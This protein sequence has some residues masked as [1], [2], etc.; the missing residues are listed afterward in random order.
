M[1]VNSIN[2]IIT[3]LWENVLKVN[4]NKQENTKDVKELMITS[5][6][7]MIYQTTTKSAKLHELNLVENDIVWHT[8]Y[9]SFE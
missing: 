8:L 2:C 4:L 3:L 1:E 7:T 5:L 9:Y 6:F